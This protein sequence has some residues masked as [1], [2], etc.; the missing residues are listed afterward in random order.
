[1]NKILSII[2]ASILVAAFSAMPSAA[3]DVDIKINT[4]ATDVLQLNLGADLALNRVEL[5]QTNAINVATVVGEQIE[6][7]NVAQEA[8]DIIQ[9]NL[10]LAVAFDAAGIAKT[11][12]TNALN[13]LSAD[14]TTKDWS[15]LNVA[16]SA[17]GIIQ[18]NLGIVGA[19]NIA[20]L[21]Q[22]NAANVIDLSV[23]VD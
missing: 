12:Q 22:V 9:G 10:G 20:N 5:D 19:G 7:V 23:N 8:G 15:D 2:A 17:T 14:L 11:A 1:V 13:V 18:G 3:A 4:G 6:D 16:Q 21:S